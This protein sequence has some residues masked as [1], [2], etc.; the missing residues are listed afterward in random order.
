MIRAF[1][2]DLDGT[3][4][5]SER[6]TAEA[7]ARALERGHGI[8]IE[9][10]DREFIIGRSWIAIYDSLKTRYPHLTWSRDEMIARTAALRDEVFAELGVT[11]LP[12]AREALRWTRAHPRALV[13]GSSRVEALQVLP[14]IGP[15]AEFAVIV[16]AEDVPRSKPAPDGYLRAI[17]AL[18]VAP[19]ECL[20][21]EDSASGI[22]AGRAAGCLVLA[23]RAGNFGGW[24]QSGAHHLLATLDELTP[25]LV[26]ELARDYG[27]GVRGTP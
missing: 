19:D 3:L 12:G 14:R 9:P 11:V 20:V 25:A 18:G 16:A 21:I 17:A 8:R 15:E 10:Y 4:V 7:M 26:E 23:I 27:S 24:D 13:T 2:F 22:A 6:E 5:D 1:L